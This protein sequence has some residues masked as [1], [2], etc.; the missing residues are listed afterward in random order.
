MTSNHSEKEYKWDAE[1]ISVASFRRWANSLKPH[2]YEKSVGVPDVFYSN[3]KKGKNIIRHRWLGPAGEL[4]V[5]LRKSKTSIADRVEVDLKFHH[6]IKI[7]DV[8]AFLL[9][10]G[11]VRTM[12]LFKN[13]VH[14]FWVRDNN[15]PISLAL[16]EVELMDEKTRKRIG[17]RR[18]LECEIDKQGPISDTE[19]MELLETYRGILTKKFKLKAPLTDSLYEIYSGKRYPMTTEK[20]SN[21]NRSK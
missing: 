12:T 5:K 20:L 19:A 9:A 10:A 21:G 1:H 4:T 15:V 11:W 13:F 18:F 17:T 2:R 16:Y 3:G 6:T 7:V 8:A 14:V